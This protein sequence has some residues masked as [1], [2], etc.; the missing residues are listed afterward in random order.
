MSFRERFKL[1]TNPFRTTPATSPDEIVWA[2]FPE[3]KARFENRI[4]RSIILPNSSLILNW[5]EYGSGKTH[6]A[7]FFNK[8]AIL[9]ELSGDN[10]RPYST[11]MTLP[12]GKDPIHSIFISIID[13][14]RIS[15]LREKA[16]E[17]NLDMSEIINAYG[18]N[19][20]IQNVLK[21]VFNVEVNETV[22]KKYLYGNLTNTELRD[23]SEYG[24][25]RRIQGDDDY[26]Y[27]ISGLY[28]CI[29]IDKKM[30]SCTILWIDEFEDIAVLSSSNIDKVNNFLR[31]IMDNTPNNLLVFINLTQSALIGVEDLSEYLYEAVRSR[32]KERNNFE[33]PTSDAFLTYLTELLAKFRVGNGQVTD[34]FPFEQNTVEYMLSKLENASIRT[35][36]DAFSLILELA[37]MEQQTSITLEYLHQNESEIIWDSI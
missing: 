12:K 18:D 3:I 6:A 23:L 27:F 30:Y 25:L 22:L 20:Q 32:I 8:V 2:G 24:I 1:S 17:V 26:I 5:G 28:T 13:K 35:F 16:R 37:D 36:N 33:L 15:E 11:V 34:L 7:R 4:K 10:P 19:L 29:G 9:D 14:L 31:E 21:A